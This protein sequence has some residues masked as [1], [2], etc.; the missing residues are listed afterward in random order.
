MSSLV[1]Q[2]KLPCYFA[3]LHYLHPPLPEGVLD[4]QGVKA[5]SSRIIC[6]LLLFL[7]C[8][9]LQLQPLALGMLS[10]TVPG[11]KDAVPTEEVVEGDGNVVQVR[12]PCLLLSVRHCT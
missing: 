12:L 7:I 5:R 11:L 1:L 10:Q 3:L 8:L 4:V 9:L 6:G 2:V